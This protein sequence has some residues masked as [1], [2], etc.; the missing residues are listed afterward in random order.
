MYFHASS[1]VGLFMS[2]LQHVYLVHRCEEADNLGKVG[3]LDWSED[4]D[5]LMCN[6]V[7]SFKIALEPVAFEFSPL[8]FMKWSN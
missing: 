1:A 4:N 3:H 8:K 2:T 7:H 6:N 5:K